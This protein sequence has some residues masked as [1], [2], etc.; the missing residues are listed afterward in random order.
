MAALILFAALPLAAHAVDKFTVVAIP[1]PQTITIKDIS[2]QVN[3]IKRNRVNMNIATMAQQGDISNSPVDTNKYVAVRREFAGLSALTPSLPW[4]T[5][6]GNH[7][8]SGAESAPVYKTYFGPTA[9]VPWPS[10]YGGSN[11]STGLSSYHTFSAGGR[12]YLVINLEYNR[13]NRF[14]PD[15]AINWAKGVITAPENRGKPTII[16]THNY[17]NTLGQGHRNRTDN[18]EKI[19]TGLVNS[20]SQVF[21]VLCGHNRLSNYQKVTN[22]VGQDVFELMANWQTPEGK[23]GDTLRLYEFDEDAKAIHVKT[24]SP[25]LN[26]YYTDGTNALSNQFDIPIDFN[27]RL[28]VTVKTGERPNK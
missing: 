20:N 6:P 4:G 14:T 22:A 7:D 8:Y 21:M 10:W 24:Y 9:F 28:G 15:E 19:F 27:K 2:G 1:D 13:E 17:L 5:V 23:G 12:N 26:T 25:S 3:W 18:G 11:S 16:N